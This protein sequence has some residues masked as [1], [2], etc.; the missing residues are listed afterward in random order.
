[1]K[2]DFKILDEFPLV[3]QENHDKLLSSHNISVMEVVPRILDQGIILH[4]A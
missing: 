3:I 1:M 4:I 2:H